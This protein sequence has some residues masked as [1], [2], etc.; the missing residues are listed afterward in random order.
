[1]KGRKRHLLVDTQGLVLKALVHPADVH[2]KEGGQRLLGPLKEVFPRMAKVWA[3]SAYR[4]VVDW[5]WETLGWNVEIVR[6]PRS[7]AW[8][9]ADMEPPPV[10]KGFIV[11][12][13]R[14]VVER[15]FAWLCRNRRLS[16]DYEVLP[17]TGEAFIYAAMTR[18]MLR[19]LTKSHA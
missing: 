11:L 13:R 1:M 10:P 16:K 2:D 7:G 3:D 4:G 18:L 12:P 6:H 8:M 19:R 15:T 5:A 14:W 17:A 9:L